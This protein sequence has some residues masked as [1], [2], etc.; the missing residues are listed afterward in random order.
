MIIDTREEQVVP[1][2]EATEFVPLKNGKRVAASTVYRWTSKGCYGVMLD[3][4]QIGGLRHTSRE[5][6][7][8]FFAEL[9][10]VKE[11]ARKYEDS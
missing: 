8:R 11:K 1:I 5:A 10:R 2:T 4:V 9:T 7:Q 3:Y 6:L